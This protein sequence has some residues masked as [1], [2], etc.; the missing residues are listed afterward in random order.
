MER[1]QLCN[2]SVGKGEK[3]QGYLKLPFTEKDEL[4][5]TIIYGHEDGPTV[6]V[7][8]GIHNAEYVGIHAMVGLAQELQPSDI[9]GILIIINIINVNGFKARTVS[10]AAEDGKNLNR[11]FPGNPNGTYTEKLADFMVKELFSRIDYYIDVHNGDWFEDLSPFIYVVGNAPAET[12]RISEEMAKCAD[13]PYYVKST[14][15][16]GAYSYAGTMGIP[17]VLLERGCNGMWTEEEAK[18]SRKDVRNILRYTGTL[19][20][21]RFGNDFQIQ[22]PRLMP[23]AHYIDAE[24]GGCWFPKKRAGQIISAGEVIGEIRDYFGNLKEQIVLNED[25]IILYQTV[26]YSV[27]DHSPLVAYGHYSSCVEDVTVHEH[28]HQHDPH[29][30]THDLEEMHEK[31]LWA[32]S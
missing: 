8:G 1:F 6:L 32:E 2:L 30:A 25:C 5:T 23:H 7:D 4:P 29:T 3:V 14:G 28:N 12:V 27:P 16:N 10:V 11:E 15:K 19:M 24:N 9:R 22:T 26:S 17:S 20:T 21:S 18:A 13:V 31:G